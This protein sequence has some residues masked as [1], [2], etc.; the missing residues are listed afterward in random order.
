[1]IKILICD[2]QEIVRE[3]LRN[4]LESDRELVVVGTAIHGQDALDHLEVV[5]PD[6][7]L[8]DLHMPIMSGPEAIRRIRANNK[9]LP[10]LVLTTYSEDTW[11]FD[12][13]RSGATGY[14]L[15]DR[16]G[17][18][19]ISIIK[20]TV[21]GG[22]Y[23]DPQVAGKLI[24]NVASNYPKEKESGIELTE[25][26]AEILNLVVKGYSNP[27]IA[28]G[29]FLSEGTVRNHM[30]VIFSKLGV[31]DRTQAAVKAIKFGLVKLNE[32]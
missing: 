3:G 13:I 23:I 28:A 1:M 12:A 19:L 30:T 6:L 11:L 4:I 26:E 2:D 22:H 16:P 17:A 24:K 20:E 31:Q 10:V 25:R 5:Q 29:L 32:L 15:K 14:I 27:E 18:E 7:V 21:Q 8:M 9:T